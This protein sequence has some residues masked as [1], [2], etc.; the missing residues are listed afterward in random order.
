[1]LSKSSLANFLVVAQVPF[2]KFVLSDSNVISN[3]I[4]NDK[5]DQIN[6]SQHFKHSNLAMLN[7]T[8]YDPSLLNN[9]KHHG[10]WCS[11]MSF[12]GVKGEQALITI[13][14]RD[15]EPVDVSDAL[16]KNWFKSRFCNDRL[17]GGSCYG[18]DGY[19]LG[20]GYSV[21]KTSNPPQEQRTNLKNYS[22]A[23]N[24]C[25]SLDPLES[26]PRPCE[27]DSCAI[28]LYY[29]SRINQYLSLVPNFNFRE[30]AREEGECY[31]G[32]PS[33]APLRCE[34]VAPKVKIEYRVEKLKPE[35]VFRKRML[36]SM[37]RRRL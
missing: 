31:R 16:C 7:Q 9:I 5:N 2:V 34:G 23:D 27:L 19:S 35:A 30:A 13:S 22:Y 24:T 4:D 1:M 29:A 21:T 26:D 11:K 14:D 8:L 15:G 6:I 3:G 12:E 18:V 17:P 37:K 10:C 33:L 32:A 28:D 25:T 20:Y 36:K